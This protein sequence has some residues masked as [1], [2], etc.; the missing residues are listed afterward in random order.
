[1]KKYF[2]LLAITLI[3]FS[4]TK[5]EINDLGYINEYSVELKNNKLI[6][7]VEEFQIIPLEY[8]SSNS[9]IGIL[10]KMEVKGNYIYF[11]SSTPSGRKFITIFDLN[12]GFVQKIE[13]LEF[14]N[15]KFGGVSNFFISETGNLIVI[16]EDGNALILNSD[17]QIVDIV[18]LPFQVD[19]IEQSSGLILS[20]SNKKAKNFQADSMFYDIF[21]LNSSFNILQ[22]KNPFQVIQG[23]TRYHSTIAQSIQP[24]KEG[25]LFTEF[26]ND[27]IYQ[28]TFDSIYVKY[29]I[30]FGDSRFDSKSYTDLVLA[31]FS[32][33]LTEK[34]KWGIHSP[35]ETENYLFAEY[36][37]KNIPIDLIL[38]K[39]N[40][41]L[42]KFS[43]LDVLNDHDVAPWPKVHNNDYYYGYFS[44]N[45]FSMANTDQI[46]K[47]PE[48]S[49]I[50]QIY[51]HIINNSNS[52][53]VRYKLI[54]L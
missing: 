10:L 35:I 21:V 38:N 4:C 8:L 2:F 50:K 25:F 32:P 49:S 31:P 14:S 47:Y 54:K 7:Y 5:S 44:E 13:N 23:E 39:E 11:L 12:G 26:L 42:I 43:P 20:Y 45:D 37:D 29:I 33:I 6:D 28:V 41:E 40:G 53:V 22:K 34:F 18:E 9:L 16:E 3:T 24:N 1:M 27:T 48:S 36:F 52:V 30:D 19:A 46:L 17:F 15:S 51:K